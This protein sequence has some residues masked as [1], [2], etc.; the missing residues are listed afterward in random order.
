MRKRFLALLTGALALVLS[1]GVGLLVA[2]GPASGGKGKADQTSAPGYTTS[3]RPLSKQQSCGSRPRRSSSC[4]RGRSEGPRSGSSPR[5]ST[6]SSRAKARTRSGRSSASSGH[7][8]ESDLRRRG[9]ARCTTRSR[10]PTGPSTTPRSGSRT[11][12][13]RTTRTCSSTKPGR[14]LD[15]E[16]LQR[17][18]VQPLHGQRR[19]HRLGEG[20]VQRGEYGSNYCGEHRL[21]PHLAVRP[22]LGERLVQRPDRGRAR[23]RRRSTRTWRSSTCGIATTTTATATSTSPTATSTTSSR[24]TPAKARR[25]AAARRAPIAIWSHRWYAFYNNIGSDRSGLQRARR[26]PDRQQQLLD[27]RLHDRA[28]ERRRRRV[29]ARVR[30]RPRPARPVRHVG[31]HR[32][33]RERDRLLDAHVVR[34]RTATTAPADGIGTSRRTW[35]R[36]RSS[37]SAG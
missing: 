36:G 31:Q 25:R 19:G 14:D 4:W 18:V 20:A 37:S 17:A 23:R 7:S 15:A 24:S 6:S 29:R 16:L 33:R 32:R 27:R 28:G 3:S 35:A 10:S 9:R 21:R 8:G 30:P 2:A 11:S 13:S 26:C 34:A 5:A 22:R 1:A 12:T